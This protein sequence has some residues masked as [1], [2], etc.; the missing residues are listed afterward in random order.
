MAGTLRGTI[1]LAAANGLYIV[2]LLLGGMIIPLSSLHGL[3]FVADLL[4][5]GALSQVMA[6]AFRSSVH[7]STQNWIVLI[8][9]AVA[10]PLAAARWFRWE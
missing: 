1:T 5:A 7:V 6:A 10:A 8:A 9:W 2:L 4:P 3:R